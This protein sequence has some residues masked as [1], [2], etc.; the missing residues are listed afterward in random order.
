M[1]K[2]HI[3]EFEDLWVPNKYDEIVTEDLWALVDLVI[4]FVERRRGDMELRPA[5]LHRLLTQYVLLAQRPGHASEIVLR[6]KP[7]VPTGWTKRAERLWQDWITYT[8]ALEDWQCEVMGRLF[9]SDV[10]HWEA[11]LDGQWRLDLFGFLRQWLRRSLATV[12][13]F[14]PAPEEVD[15]N[16]GASKIDPYLLEHGKPKQ[17]RR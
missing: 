9:G 2:N 6:R 17:R 14:D 11:G 8:F 4:R 3:M 12:E 16:E 7:F 1:Q 13:A 5:Q 15:E 10:R